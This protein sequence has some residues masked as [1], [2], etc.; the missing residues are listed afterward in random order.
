MISDRIIKFNLI[1]MVF[2]KTNA[3]QL[4]LEQVQERK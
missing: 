3:Y 4:S 1:I 2:V